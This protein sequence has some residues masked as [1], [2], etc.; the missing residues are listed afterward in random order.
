MHRGAT[1]AED[2]GLEVGTSADDHGSEPFWE[3]F[4]IPYADCKEELEGTVENGIL[5]ETY[6]PSLNP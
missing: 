5:T 2:E 6:S 3:L 4:S 1:V